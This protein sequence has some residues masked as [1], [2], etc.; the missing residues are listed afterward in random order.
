[1]IVW[2]DAPTDLYKWEKGVK[3]PLSPNFGTHEFECP[4]ANKACFEQIIARTLI[5]KLQ[6]LRDDVGP[7]NVTSG[8]RCA[9][10][11][12]DLKNRG[13]ETATG[14]SQHQLG[15]AGDITNA[16]LKKTLDVADTLFYAIGIGH[17]FLHVDLRDDKK[18]RWTYVKR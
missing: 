8:Y 12:Q 15:K 3:Q 11:Q 2:Y 7:L 1:M 17:T 14:V 10:Y 5:T 13:Y 6:T 9:A 16:D 4:C 18:R